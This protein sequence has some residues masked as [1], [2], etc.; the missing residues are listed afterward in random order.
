[1]KKLNFTGKDLVLSFQHMFAM[2]GSTIIVPILAGMSIP[3]TLIGAG[4]GTIL[5]YFITKRKVPVFLGSSFAFLPALIMM[6]GN[7]ITKEAPQFGYVWQ[8]NSLAVM[9]ALVCAG[10]VYVVLAGVIKLVGA[11]KVKRLF[12]PIVVGPVIIIIGMILAPKMFWNN[13]IGF[14]EWNNIA[15]WKSWTTA[16]VTA[17]TIVLVNAFAKPKS[18]L[19]VIP[20]LLGFVVGYIY[21]ACVGLVSFAGKFSWDNIVIFQHIDKD[22]SFW[23]AWNHPE[24]GPAVGKALLAIVPI[25]LVTFMEHLGD[26]SANS[27]VCGQDFMVDPGLH[28][29]VL[30]DGIATMVSGLIGGPANTTYGENTAVLS[31]TKN[32]NPRNV[33]VAA[34]MSV[35]FGVFSV[36]S[37]LLGTIPAPVIGGASIVLF[38]MISGNGL[39]ALTDAKVDFNNSKNMMVVAT[40]LAVGLGLGAMS[41]AGDITGDTKLKIMAGSVEISP[42]AIATVLAIILNLIIPSRKE[43]EQDEPIVTLTSAAAVDMSD[44]NQAT[45]KTENAVIEEDV[46]GVNSPA[47]GVTSDIEDYQEES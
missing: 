41:L 12:P 11:D 26:I 3:M 7:N 4:L 6:I 43:E 17:G 47:V 29:T 33:L 24:L 15:P 18:F 19:K 31:I 14:S 45:K 25:A 46:E 30:G 40:V 9:I 22:L 10:L 37:C 35:V 1:M 32:Y 38:G 2:L 5:F 28:R 13:I 42:L 27:T 23:T 36:F 44:Y 16:I 21:S 8:T 39:R 20:I 34:I